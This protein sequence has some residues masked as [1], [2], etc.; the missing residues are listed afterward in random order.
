VWYGGRW[1][2]RGEMIQVQSVMEFI[3]HIINP[4]RELLAGRF[5]KDEFTLYAT[6]AMKI[7]WD[8]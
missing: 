3:E 2:L 7:L 1:G 5:T 6:M 8:A 4:P